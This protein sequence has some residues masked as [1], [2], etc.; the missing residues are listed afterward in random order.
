[1]GSSDR[2]RMRRGAF[3]ARGRLLAVAMLPLLLLGACGKKNAQETELPPRPVVAYRVTNADVFAGRGLPGQ[4][5]ASLEAALSFRVG[6]RLEERRVKTGDTVKEGDVVASLDP[7]PYQAEVD[8]VSA[9]LQRA[10]AAFTNAA[11]QLDRDKQLFAKDI[12]AK[13]RLETSQS[14]ADQAQAE[15]QSLEA[16]LERRK[17]DVSY[18]VLR[19]PFDGVVAAVFAEVFE[20][21]KPQQAVMRVIDPRKIEM[22]VSVPESLISFV[23]HAVDI[24]ATFDVFPGVDIPGTIS[25]IGSE[26]SETTRTYAV[27]VL[28]SPP[29]EVA[30]IPGM[31]GRVRARPGPEI[32]ER[33]KG[34]VVPM[35]AVFSPDDAVGSFVWVIGDGNTVSRQQVTLGEPVVGGVTVKDGLSPGALVVQAG[36]HSLKEGQKVRVQER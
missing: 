30:I 31:S 18:T 36:V 2:D 29:P 7:A 33:L 10:R 14:N 22:V 5:R 24:N 34:V 35:S 13:A 1:M 11:S 9:T 26:P 28:L 21:I 16:T 12:V 3:A 8:S 20:E 27:K 25:E 17:L 4:A 19:A 32:A 6:G 15:V 23:P